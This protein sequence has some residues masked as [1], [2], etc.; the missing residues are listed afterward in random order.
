VRNPELARFFRDLAAYL[1]MDDVPFKPR[2]YEKAALAIESCDRPLA[3]LHL[4]GG[5]K[6]LCTIPGIGKSMAEKLAEILTTGKCQAH[7]VYRLRMPVDL[8]ALTAVEGVGPKAVKVLYDHLGIR[9]IEDLA[10]AARAGKIRPLPHFGERSEQ[11]ILKA[12]TVVQAGT[13]R[14]PLAVVLPLVETVAETLASVRG[15]ERV[16]IA[17]SIRRRRETIGDA[18]LL[19]VARKAEP[20]MRAFAGLSQVARVLGRGSTKCS[21]KLATGLQVDLRV[22]PAE[23]FG[24]ALLYFTG[25]KAHNVV[26]RQLAIKRKLKLNEYGLLRGTR[27]VAGRTEEEIYDHLGLAYIPPELREDQGEIEAARQGR[28]PVLIEPGALRGDLQTQTN[29]TDGADSIEAMAVAARAAGLEYIAITD[30]T[31]SLAMTGGSDATK[32]RKQMR[33]IDRLNRKLDGI[34]ILTGAEVNVNKDGTLD[35]DDETLA[36]LDVVGGGSPLALQPPARRPD[37]SHLPGDQQSPRRHP[38]PP[39]RPRDRQARALRR[40]HRY[41]HRDGEG[42]G[43]DPRARRLPR[44]ARSARRACPQGDRGR[45][46]DRHRLRRPQREAPVVPAPPRDRS[47]A[48]RL[49]ERRRRAQHPTGGDVP[50]RPQGEGQ[51]RAGSARLSVGR[52]AV[53]GKEGTVLRR[54]RPTHPAPSLGACR[55]R[56]ILVDRAPRPALRRGHHVAVPNTGPDPFE[57]LSAYAMGLDPEGSVVVG[58]VAALGLTVVKLAE[59][60]LRP[61]PARIARLPALRRPRPQGHAH[62]G[63]LGR[64]LQSRGCLPATRLPLRNGSSARDRIDDLTPV[65]W[66]AV[67]GNDR[68]VEVEIGPGRGETLLAAATTRPGTNFFGIEHDTRR[69]ETLSGV[70]AA[71]GLA[72][73]R[74]VAGDARCIVGRLVPDASVAALLHLTSLTP[75]RRRATAAAASPHRTSPGIFFGRWSS[76]GGFTCSPTSLRCSPPSSRSSRALASSA[77]R[78]RSR[79]PGGPRRTTSASTP[80]LARTTLASSVPDEDRSPGARVLRSEGIST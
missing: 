34:R 25:S 46:A 19:A 29:W 38:L 12:L 61:V 67:F 42:D 5:A 79:P 35:I 52:G 77:A 41:D 20:V 22:V 48:P 37:P 65:D 58:G 72:N 68:P 40:R 2:A 11:R 57:G 27:R 59:R 39:D 26:L 69:A 43:D 16:A 4:E 15:V 49:G 64:P 7:E 23:S 66:P 75:G 17:G 50:G 70:A 24:A 3:E 30:H 60:T 1:E 78:G 32:L 80:E 9:T 8:A 44:P 63:K 55:F 51:Q 33:E 6:A 21:V 18:D 28:L 10:A 47:G 31:V 53:R 45:H 56:V 76:T 71:R 73:V 54:R 14:Q 62:S 74:I 36:A 13:A